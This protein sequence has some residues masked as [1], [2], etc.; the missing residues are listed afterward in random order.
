MKGNV[1]TARDMVSC[2]L[3]MK[4]HKL[5]LRRFTLNVKCLFLRFNKYVEHVS[6][7]INK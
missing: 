5:C 3:L 2:Y 4:K 6:V 1:S 7:F